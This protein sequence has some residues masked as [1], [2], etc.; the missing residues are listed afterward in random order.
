[1]PHRG[2][3][4]ARFPIFLVEQAEAL[5]LDRRYV[6]SEAD[7]S[8]KE[9]NDPDSRV[10]ARK[11]IHLWRIVMRE[12]DDVDL[13]IR[14]GKTISAKAIGLVGY[15]ML[16]SPTLGEALSRLVRY[17]CIIDET[18]PPKLEI[19]GDRAEYS[20]EP[21]PEQRV[22]LARTGRLRPRRPSCHRPR[23]DRHR[24]GAGRSALPLSRGTL[25]SVSPSRLLSL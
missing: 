1:M 2:T 4:L 21:I 9:L 18:Y 20:L 3:A 23:A 14:I 17:G 24:S 25:R 5:G 22:T 12:I 19:V 11:T 15:S 6:M 7:L 8:R 10:Q 13:G 16:H